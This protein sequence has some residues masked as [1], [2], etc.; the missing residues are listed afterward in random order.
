MSGYHESV[1]DMKLEI[2]WERSRKTE[3]SRAGGNGVLERGPYSLEFTYTDPNAGRIASE[4]RET[5]DQFEF[6]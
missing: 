1:G 5:T 6:D 3:I 2:A 4:V